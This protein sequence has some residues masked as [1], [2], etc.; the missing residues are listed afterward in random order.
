MPNEASELASALREGKFP[1]A[2][3]AEL[4]AAIEVI[5]NT[6]A[7]PTSGVAV[8]QV[9]GIAKGLNER[10]YFNLTRPLAEAWTKSKG[11]DATVTRIHAQAL[12]NSDALDEAEKLLQ[13]GL[14]QIRKPGAGAQAISEL[15][16]YE[17]LLGRIAK[18]RFVKSDDQDFLAGAV[19]HYRAPYERNESKPYWHGINYAAL[20]ARQSREQGTSYAEAQ[21]VAQAVYDDV[22]ARYAREAGNPW[23]AATAS[24]AALALGRC[25]DAV[26]WLELFLKHPKLKPFESESFSRQ[27]RE[28]WQGDATGDDGSCANR[29]LKIVE[30]HVAKKEGRWSVSPAEVDAKLRLLQLDRT[31]FQQNFTGQSAF[32]TDEIASLLAACPRVGSICN[33][34]NARFG[35]GFLIAGNVLK[36]SFGKEPVFVTNAHVIGKDVPKALPPDKALIT[37]EVQ[38][39]RAGEP[40][41]H[42]VKEVLFTSEPAPLGKPQE[43]GLDVTIVRLQGLRRDASG[44]SA[45]D[46]LPPVNQHAKAFVIG[47][48]GGGGLRISVHD[49]QLLAIDAGRRLLHYRT[50][51]DNGNSGSP[52]FDNGCKVMGV[53]RGGLKEMPMLDGPGTYEA[54]E[55]VTLLAIQRMLN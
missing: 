34:A 50:P 15:L 12:I 5:T 40:K 11:F 49:S 39:E 54:N 51:T 20:L 22:E 35:T 7:Q 27:L 18:Q 46:Q 55:G 47:Y 48:P 44:L 23:V 2:A 14:Q 10:V 37:F 19:D 24:E 4:A 32:T 42:K 13:D 1:E 53:H 26:R 9:R 30:R 6:L 3:P 41:F 43:R 36:E 29:L 33:S 52:V 38:N 17:G 25:E 45:A 28:I 21:R 16:E 31:G 8:Q